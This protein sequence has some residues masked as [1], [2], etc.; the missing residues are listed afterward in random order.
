M[1]KICLCIDPGH[2]SY[3]R[4]TSKINWGCEVDGVKEVELNLKLAKLLKKM[5]LKKGFA[6]V[7][8]RYDNKKVVSN[9]QRAETAKKYNVSLFFR[10]HA[11]SERHKDS[12]IRGVKTIYPPPAAKNIWLKSWEIALTIH[13]EIIKKT[14]LVDRGVCDERITALKNKQGMLTGTYFANKYK[15]PTVLLEA[16]YLSN[17]EDRLWILNPSNQKLMMQAVAE[18]IEKYFKNMI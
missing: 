12:E 1:K 8:T 3:F 5:L 11:D 4:G 14:G 7:L 2:P 15:I 10:I 9:K 13:R 18:G 16:V 17:P 6:V